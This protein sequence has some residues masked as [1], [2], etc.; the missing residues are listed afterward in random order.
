MLLQ[1]SLRN[2]DDKILEKLVGV[3]NRAQTEIDLREDEQSSGHNI[4]V[5]R[6]LSIML[7]MP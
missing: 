5:G 7:I 6:T 2:K 4:T 3:S 1:N